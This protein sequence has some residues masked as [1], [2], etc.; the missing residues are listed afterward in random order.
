MTF[1]TQGN[2]L[3]ELHFSS[4]SPEET[5]AVGEKVGRSLARGDIVALRGTLGAGKTCFAKGIARGLGVCEEVTSPTYTII[6]EYQGEKLPFYHIDAYRLNGDDDFTALGGE[7]FLYGDG[8]SVI[9]WSE[10]IPGSLPQDALIVELQ[11]R[12]GGRNIRITGSRLPALER[13]TP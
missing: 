13:E 7:E 3:S 12:E 9:E 6:A 11:F 2:F 4:S 10:R 8:V 5:M 1:P